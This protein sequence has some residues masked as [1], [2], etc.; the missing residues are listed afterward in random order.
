MYYP[1]NNVLEWQMY[2]RVLSRI[3]DRVGREEL[4]DIMRLPLVGGLP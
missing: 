3:E 4:V 1:F 2:Y